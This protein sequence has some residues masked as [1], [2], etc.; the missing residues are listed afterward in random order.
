MKP[1]ILR[2]LQLEELTLLEE[3]D[4]VCKKNNIEYFIAYGTALGAIRH[5]GFI[6]WDDDIDVMMTTENY[7]KFEKIATKEL[8]KDFFF[9]SLDTEKHLHIYWNKIRKNNTISAIKGQEKTKT[10]LGIC[11]DI[12]PLSKY[13]TKRRVQKKHYLYMKM[14]LIILETELY[15]LHFKEVNRKGKILYSV[16]SI[17]PLFIRNRIAKHLVKKVL[18]Y[19]GP[20]ENYVE[21]S[22]L[23]NHLFLYPKELIGKT[24]STKFENK[25]FPILKDYDKYLTITYGNYM[26]LPPENERV[27]HGNLTLKFSDGEEY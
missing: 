19:N 17:I 20:Y 2:K 8:G 4:R 9:Q 5:Q 13:P 27:A 14:A 24:I 23:Y 1:E 16:L 12:F 10:H 21:Y 7:N 26:K 18:N 22:E 11:M 15:K 3:L 6:P 25:E